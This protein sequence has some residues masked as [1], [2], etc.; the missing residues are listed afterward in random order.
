MCAAAARP[1]GA[2]RRRTAARDRDHR[3]ERRACA[4]SRDG[5]DV[6]GGAAMNPNDLIAIAPELIV[7]ITACLVIV[8]DSSLSRSAARTWLPILAVVGL[9]VALTAP[10]LWPPFR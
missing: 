2:A 5:P 1:H 8:A 10:V 9:L 4:P 7:T 6:L 3:A